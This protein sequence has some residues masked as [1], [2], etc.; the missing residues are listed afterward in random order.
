MVSES[1]IFPH[2]GSN[3]ARP[4]L[5]SDVGQWLSGQWKKLGPAIKGMDAA[6]IMRINKDAFN[7]MIDYFGEVDGWSTDQAKALILKAKEFWNERGTFS[8]F[9]IDTLRSALFSCL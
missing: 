1:E 5:H 7:E 8:S 9:S 3:N 6:E 4:L 2:P